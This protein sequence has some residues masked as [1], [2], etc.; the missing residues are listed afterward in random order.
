MITPLVILSN[1]SV[2]VF[3]PHRLFAPSKAQSIMVVIDPNVAG[4]NGQVVL[5]GFAD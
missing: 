1:T 2:S 5:I 3:Y 4:R